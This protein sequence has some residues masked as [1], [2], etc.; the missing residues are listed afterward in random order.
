M[1]AGFVDIFS[2]GHFLQIN[3]NSED[4]IRG[5]LML[6]DMSGRSVFNC[7]VDFEKSVKVELR[8]SKGMYISRLVTDTFVESKL[9]WID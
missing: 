8:L 1:A 2:F 5:E 6:Y 9:V 3:N 7:K 4:K